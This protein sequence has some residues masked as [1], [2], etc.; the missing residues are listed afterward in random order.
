VEQLHVGRVADTDPD[1]SRYI[2]ISSLD[3]LQEFKVVS[4]IYPAEFGREAPPR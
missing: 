3:A 4:G 1:F 2:R